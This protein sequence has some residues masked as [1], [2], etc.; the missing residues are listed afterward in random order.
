MGARK[1]GGPVPPARGIGFACPTKPPNAN[2]GLS[3]SGRK[4]W[5]FAGSEGGRCAAAIYTLIVTAKLNTIDPQ[6]WLA[7]VL[8]GLRD[9]SSKRIHELNA[10]R[11]EDILS[12]ATQKRGHAFRACRGCAPLT[13]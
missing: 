10:I 8:A 3:P 1:G 6:A 9:H 5:T 12:I 4:N 11:E 7:D 13:D 2:C